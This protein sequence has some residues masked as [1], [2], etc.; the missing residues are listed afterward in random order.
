MITLGKKYK[1]ITGRYWLTVM[2]SFLKQSGFAICVQGFEATLVRI[3][4][5][6]SSKE[7]ASKILSQFFVKPHYLAAFWS[8]LANK[9]GQIFGFITKFEGTS[10]CDFFQD[11]DSGFYTGFWA[12]KKKTG[13]ILHVL[14]RVTF[15]FLVLSRPFLSEG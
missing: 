7:A 12:G 9:R 15:I 6:L 4:K 2:S 1:V 8:K 3:L 5:E 10:F 14:C 11:P 13:Q